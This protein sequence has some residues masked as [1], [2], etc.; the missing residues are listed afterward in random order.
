MRSFKVLCCL[1]CLVVLCLIGG[2]Q[3]ASNDQ[4][5]IF[6]KGLLPVQND[7]TWGYINS[8]N[9]YKIPS[10]Y[11]NAKPFAANGLAAVSLGGA[12]GY[13][14]TDGEMV[15]EAAY[16]EAETFQGDLAIVKSEGLYGY[17]NAKGEIVIPAMYQ[18]AFPFAENDLARVCVDGQYGYIIKSGDWSIAP[19]YQA[20]ADFSS[21]GMAAVVI[22]EK[23]GYIDASGEIVIEPAFEE[24]G[25]FTDNGLAVASED[26][27][28][29]GYINAQG[30]WIITPQYDAA[31][32]FSEG[33]AIVT[34]DNTVCGID[35]E[36]E[37]LFS[38]SAEFAV[39]SFH[40]GKAWCYN[41]S[42]GYGGYIDTEGNQ[43]IAE[44]FKAQLN[45]SLSRFGTDH[46]AVVRIGDYYGVA[47]TEGKFIINPQY[48]AI[49]QVEDTKKGIYADSALQRLFKYG[50]ARFPQV[51]SEGNFMGYLYRTRDGMHSIQVEDGLLPGENG[52]TAVSLDGERW[53]YIDNQ[54]N[55]VIEPRWSK[56]QNFSNGLA[57][58]GGDGTYGYIDEQ[59]ETVGPG[60]YVYATD[61]PSNGKAFVV[62]YT[63]NWAI[64][65]VTGQLKEL[66]LRADGSGSC[67]YLQ[68]GYAK[69]DD[70]IVDVTGNVIYK[71]EEKEYDIANDASFIFIWGEGI[72]DTTT[73]TI[74]EFPIENLQRATAFYFN[75]GYV[76]YAG[77]EE[78]KKYGLMDEKGEM[79]INPIYTYIEET[80]IIGIYVGI[81]EAGEYQ[82][83]DEQGNILVEIKKEDI[84]GEMGEVVPHVLFTKDGFFSLD[85]GEFTVEED[86][87]WTPEEN[88]FCIVWEQPGFVAK[89]G[90][91]IQDG[92]IVYWIGLSV[93][94]QKE[95]RYTVINIPGD[96]IYDPNVLYELFITREYQYPIS[97]YFQSGPTGTWWFRN[98]DQVRLITRDGELLLEEMVIEK[99]YREYGIDEFH[100]AY[101]NGQWNYINEQGE[102]IISQDVFEGDTDSPWIGQED[103]LIY[104]YTK[105][106]MGQVY[107]QN[108]K[109]LVEWDWII[110]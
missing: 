41:E 36:G 65:S 63:G 100:W 107:D 101:C 92:N 57:R 27:S 71:L 24:A 108:G 54:C 69:L 52:L 10:K 81:L 105:D 98:E 79:I 33:I 51:D 89:M 60:Q 94:G 106:G 102:I 16:G 18:E 12:W 78:D 26:G 50:I 19:Q 95:E 56:A 62:N 43:V 37:I 49:G 5:A 38:L 14:N 88:R 1:F 3:E 77:A 23:A 84:L 25:T 2:C 86:I 70:L 73:G 103:G 59:G 93:H 15:I 39:D 48:E 76:V 31:A 44:Q 21:N 4:D 68:N 22:E 97:L 8:K 109:L 67:S 29:Y 96:I 85:T 110:Q 42:N 17:I 28:L 82:F 55:V 58:I 20:A 46:Y 66:N 40:D 45:A 83:L 6:S 75:E 90:G 7:G 34:K 11:E 72:F 35:E 74:K 32:D 91:D 87:E 53:G 30:E 80:D 99:I 9:E 13:I 47:N 104:V 64:V 61:F